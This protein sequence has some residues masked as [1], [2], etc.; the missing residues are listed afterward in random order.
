M[1]RGKGRGYAIFILSPFSD[2]YVHQE[3]LAVWATLAVWVPTLA[4]SAPSKMKVWPAKMAL[5]S[6]GGGHG[7]AI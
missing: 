7:A 5:L 2:R 6:P 4:R 1:P 3:A